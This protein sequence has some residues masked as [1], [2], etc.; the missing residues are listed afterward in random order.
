MRLDVL[1]FV[2]GCSKVLSQMFQ[3]ETR[4]LYLSLDVLRFGGRMF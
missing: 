1:T 3:L 2:L 4:S